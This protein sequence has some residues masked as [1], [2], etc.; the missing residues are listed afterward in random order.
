MMVAN[1]AFAPVR[2]AGWRRGFANL[3]RKENRAWWGTRRWLVQAVLWTVVVNGLL[4]FILFGLPPLMAQMDPAQLEGFEPVAQGLQAVGQVGTVALAMGAILLA[5]DQI[6]GERQSGVTEWILSK[7][8]SRT[9]YIVSKLAADAIG[10]VVILVG[11]PM[12]LGYGQ[13]W[14]VNGTPLPLIPFLTGAAALALHTLFYLCLT[15]MMG[16]V[17]NGREVLLGVPLGVL[18]GGLIIVS[19]VG[20]FGLFTPWSMAAVLPAVVLEQSMPLPAWVPLASTA[21]LAGI[22]VAL[23]LYSFRKLEF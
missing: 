4:A 2:E 6:L 20:T 5:Q 16:V 3:F 23:T 19:F 14:L 12:A 18:F 8:V 9:A 1:A 17:A 22:C 21:V 10:V 13:F 15:L 7:P 11:L